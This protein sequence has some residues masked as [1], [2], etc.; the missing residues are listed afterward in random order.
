[1][2]SPV[3]GVLSG[4]NANIRS[5]PESARQS[6]VFTNQERVSEPSRG[7]SASRRQRSAIT[8][9]EPP[10]RMISLRPLT[11]LREPR[12]RSGTPEPRWLGCSALGCGTWR[13]RGV[14]ECRRRPSATTLGD[15]GA[16]SMSDARAGTTGTPCSAITTRVTA[17]ASASLRSASPRRAGS[18]P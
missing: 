11:A 16:R 18:K 6:P 9:G 3:L 5:C 15:S 1:V 12:C 4:P 8:S 14:S 7:S 2:S 17:C 13:S 10:S